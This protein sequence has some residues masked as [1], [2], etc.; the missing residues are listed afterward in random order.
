MNASHV[1]AHVG[2][3]C[4]ILLSWPA[5]SALPTAGEK[6][7]TH[8]V[9]QSFN[10]RPFSY[11][12]EF[13]EE[14]NAHRLYRLRFPSPVTTAV[15]ENNT[16]PGDYYL[17]RGDDGLR[18]PAVL[19]LHILH[20][21]FELERITCSTLAAHG[22][23]A[24]MIKL[25]Y[26]G[27]RS[28][29]ESRWRLL[30]NPQVFLGAMPQGIDDVRRAVDVLASRPEVNP[31]AVGAIGISLG[32]IV[33]ATA[34][35]QEPRIARAVLILAG[36]DLDHIIHH[37]RETRELSQQLRT[38]PPPARAAVDAALAQVDPLSCAAL[39][40]AR[41]QQ[42]R[43]LMVNAAEDEVIPPDCTRRLATALGIADRVRWLEGLG[44]YTALAA[45]PDILASAVDFF[46]VDLP[47][48]ARVP[49]ARP[50]PGPLQAVMR[51]LNQASLLV[52]PDPQQ[53]RG[54]LV[55]LEAD[56]TP[57]KGKP[58]TVRLR[59]V[60]G[61]SGRFRIEAH[62][63]TLGRVALGQGDYPW[64]L[65]AG[66]A[67]FKGRPTAANQRTD[68]LALANPQHVVKLRVVAGALSAAGMAP[69]VLESLAIVA[70][71]S[72]PTEKAVRI[73]TKAP[74]HDGGR[75]VLKSDGGPARLTF[76]LR[77]T[78]VE[79]R[80]RQWQPNTVI[81]AELFLEPA[82]VA[83]REVPRA[84][85]ERMFAAMFNLAMDSL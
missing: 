19:C 10:G 22:I 62:L 3:L 16:V 58:L 39:L 12:I 4:A 2:L 47:A 66:K 29:A 21:N 28:P 53:G 49:S 60:R 76:T 14:A 71:D 79:I 18:R 20:G 57:A 50:Q 67:V 8:A 42:G 64:L 27:E 1:L 80:F 52:G 55:D 56:L 40:R 15:A 44:H 24:L 83:S 37:A 25:P 68:P 33:A 61:W 73:E 5:F 30:T 72:T 85:L 48:T 31:Q 34:A 75:L 69:Q 78:R 63:P 46:A 65:S 70:D 54:H 35:A 11:Q 7:Q 43:V 59:L 23:P 9:A 51:L 84:D 32:G 74:R 36:G 38:L 6:P 81:P 17:P 77:G 13:V 26:Y 45:L 41:A 82:G